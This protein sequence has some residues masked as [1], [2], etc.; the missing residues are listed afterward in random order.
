MVFAEAPSERPWL[1]RE[2]GSETEQL[3]RALLRAATPDLGAVGDP[4]PPLPTCPGQ[5]PRPDPAPP[6]AFV[7]GPQTF[8]W[9]PLPPAPREARGPARTYRLLRASRGRPESPP[10]PSL[11]TPHRHPTPEPRG[12]PRTEEL[13]SVEGPQ[14]LGSC[15]MCQAPFAPTL[16]QLDVDSHLAQ[17]LAE[18]TDDVAW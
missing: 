15:P 1:L 17:C 4:L 8:L 9:P 14:A 7:V 10:L 16:S 2:G 18:S 11:P 12:A 3:W 5:E 6:E 13:P